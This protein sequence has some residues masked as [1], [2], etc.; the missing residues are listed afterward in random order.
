MMVDMGVKSRE[1]S[2]ASYSVSKEA[3]RIV[4]EIKDGTYRSVTP[5]ERAIERAVVTILNANGLLSLSLERGVLPT[6]KNF[7]RMANKRNGKE[8]SRLLREDQG[9]AERR[10]TI[11]AELYVALLLTDQSARSRSPEKVLWKRKS[12]VKKEGYETPFDINT[13]ELRADGVSSLTNAGTGRVSA[14]STVADKAATVTPLTLSRL[15]AYIEDEDR[16]WVKSFFS[17]KGALGGSTGLAK[18]I[19]SGTMTL[20]ESLLVYTT[21]MRAWVD[22]YHDFN[23]LPTANEVD[24]LYFIEGNKQEA[25]KTIERKALRSYALWVDHLGSDELNRALA[26]YEK[27]KIQFLYEDPLPDNYY[28]ANDS[29]WESIYSA[30]LVYAGGIESSKRLFDI[31]PYAPVAFDEDTVAG[32]TADGRGKDFFPGAEVKT[33]QNMKLP[34]NRRGNTGVEGSS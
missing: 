31:P 13:L 14:T 11:V 6:A 21:I 34:V 1:N 25:A 3:A 5:D 17:D 24:L 20:E 23:G 12:N 27:E 15:K 18:K 9:K 29:M 19:E 4:S 16:G 28:T 30:L 32:A 26:P 8:A 7:I 22:L 10:R 33:H 2:N